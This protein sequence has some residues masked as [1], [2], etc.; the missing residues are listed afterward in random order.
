MQKNAHALQMHRQN[1]AIADRAR[2]VRGIVRGSCASRVVE[3][4]AWSGH[5]NGL[6]PNCGGMSRGY[7]KFTLLAQH[8][9]AYRVVEGLG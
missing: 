7:G 5:K 3:N 1:T 2:I 4:L 6:G 9:C 8:T